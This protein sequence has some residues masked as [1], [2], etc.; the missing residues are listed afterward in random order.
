MQTEWCG[1]RTRPSPTCS[2]TPPQVPPPHP[3]PA[4][5]L[6]RSWSMSWGLG[7]AH[8]SLN[9]F[10]IL[11]PPS[12]EKPC[13]QSSMTQTLQWKR[14]VCCKKIY[15]L[16][17]QNALN[18]HANGTMLRKAPVQVEVCACCNKLLKKLLDSDLTLAGSTTYDCNTY[19]KSRWYFWLM[20]YTCKN[21][22]TTSKKHERV[23]KYNS[24][25]PIHARH[26]YQRC[27]EHFRSKLSNI[28]STKYSTMQNVNQP[29]SKP[30]WPIPTN[31][32]SGIQR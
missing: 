23:Q 17:V 20:V 26:T 14:N 5:V 9:L 15:I 28:S 2:P 13:F 30:A 10:L 12:F 29:R 16:R 31:S 1:E 6:S 27:H 4:T 7:Q 8:P 18:Y 32:T 21:P 24:S 19:I 22:R 3:T 11:E 25:L